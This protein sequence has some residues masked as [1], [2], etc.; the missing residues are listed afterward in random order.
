MDES[1]DG[2][3]DTVAGAEIAAP[4]PEGEPWLEIGL[5]EAMTI[6]RASREERPRC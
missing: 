5:R 4:E 2:G 3:N 6:V 1:S